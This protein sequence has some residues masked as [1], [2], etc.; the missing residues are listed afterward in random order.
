[1]GKK[2]KN[3]R[4]HGRNYCID[5][6]TD[7]TGEAEFMVDQVICRKCL[8]ERNKIMAGLKLPKNHP[9]REIYHGV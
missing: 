5:C 9:L 6:G 7:V 2:D 8:K 1:M 3:K 4:E